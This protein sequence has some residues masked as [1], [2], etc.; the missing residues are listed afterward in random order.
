MVEYVTK[1]EVYDLLKEIQMQALLKGNQA[2]SEVVG[3]AIRRVRRM[4]AVRT[5][6]ISNWKREPNRETISCA[7]CGYT[8]VVYRNSPF[9]PNCGRS[10]VNG[11]KK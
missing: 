6:V 4:Y 5:N 2:A 7:N 3:D 8:T 11:V 9:C 10:M 1:E